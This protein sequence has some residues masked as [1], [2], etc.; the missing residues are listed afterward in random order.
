[1]ELNPVQAIK[2]CADKL[3]MK[4][5]F[6]QA[7]VKTPSTFV[8]DEGIKDLSSN[9]FIQEEDLPF[10][11]IAKKLRHS[12]G[13]GMQKINNLEEFQALNNKNTYYFEPFMNYTREYRIH[14]SSLGEYFYTCRKLL[15]Q[16]AEDR[17]FRNNQN[18]VWYIESNPSFNKP[19]TWDAIVADCV[20]A[21]NALGLDFAAADVKVNKKGN[22][23]ILELNSAPSFGE[24][25]SLVSQK[26]IEYL[27]KLIEHKISNQC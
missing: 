3:R 14:V 2:N 9:E 1:V 22:W 5:L 19:D 11:L 27:P 16:D 21:L 4:E 6:H 26:Y 20:T 25:D 8:F 17:W 12:R 7:G 24:K 15:K 23:T 10:P 13:R 18:S